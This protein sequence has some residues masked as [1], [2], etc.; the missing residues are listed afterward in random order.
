M[1]DWTDLPPGAPVLRWAAAAPEARH[2]P[3]RAR[4]MPDWVDYRFAAAFTDPGPLPCR[5]ALLD[6][7]PRRAVPCPEGPFPDL[8][9]GMDGGEIDF[10]TFCFR[11]TL[12]ARA[13]RCRVRGAGPARFRLSTCGGLRLWLDGTEAA[14]FEPFTR[15][16]PQ[17]TEA[18]LELPARPALLTL[19]LEDLHERDT[20]CFFALTLL[21][22]A[23]VATALPEGFDA[24]GVAAA[25][26]V[27]ASL[28]TD[29]LF[30]TSGPVRLV[31]DVAPPA[32]LRLGI[33]DFAPFGRGGLVADPEA[34]NA[35]AATLTPEAPGAVIAEAGTAPPG[36][37]A[38]PVEARVGA[39]RLVRRLGTTILPPGHVVTGDVAARKARA[40]EL[41]AAHGGFEPSVAALLALRG[42]APDRV[43]RIVAATLCTIEERWDCSDF[44]ILPLLRLWRDARETLDPA[45]R[46]RLRAA[47]LGYRY[48]LDEPGDDAMWFWS[49]NHVLCFHAAQ[50][51]AG[52]LMPDEVFPNSGRTG[53]AQAAEAARRL[54]LWF[55]AI[56]AQGLCEW[57]SAAYYP[58]DLLGLLTLH[59]MAGDFRARAAEV[60]DGIFAMAA[61]HTTGG[62]PAGTQGRCYEKELLAGPVTELGSVMAIALGGAF[63]P[64]HDRAAALLC[65]S[66]YAPPGVGAL[67]A[68]PA[69][70]WLEARYTQGSDPA[71]RLS[72]WKSAEAQLATVSDL[73]TG[74]PGHQA[75][76]LDVQLARHPMARLW[77]NHPGEL[78][79]WGDRRPSLLAG[80]HVMP[81]V[82]QAG[83]VAMAVWDLDRP[84]TQVPFTQA[85]AA[86]EAFGAPLRAGDWMVFAGTVGLWCSAPLVPVGA[87]LCRGAL[88]RAEAQR[89]G[90][91]VAL[92]RPG[93]TAAAFAQRLAAA[94]VGFDAGALGLTAEGPGAEALALSFGEGLRAGGV[95]RPFATR[96]TEPEVAWD[97]GP[98]GPWRARLVPPAQPTG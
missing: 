63:R 29:R 26:A 87:G 62:T 17:A 51:I 53:R 77:I 35:A 73:G 96:A 86:P 75:Q 78:K 67:A 11:P 94:R 32:P 33:A 69:G 84:W 76:V 8:V 82:A 90:W 27:M 93:E 50:L 85:F 9:L 23:G 14:V 10:S 13:F 59:D 58:I 48:W 47:V 22:G 65:L 30:Y 39:A 46:D 44:S 42:E 31:A 92:R 15:N 28:R 98:P 72:V 55:D 61:L 34:R 66:A 37:V 79:P 57:N 49:E 41:I 25:A 12:I 2:Y 1:A 80:S 21:D 54:G 71:G 68:P 5:E 74:G 16:R 6:A 24:S 52:R 7:L 83:P 91:V 20:V 19:R 43:A 60:M 4:P 45:L 38:L 3:G 40:A 88:W 56:G 81:R 95:A 64:G 70:R 18:V 36:C 89:V 97:G